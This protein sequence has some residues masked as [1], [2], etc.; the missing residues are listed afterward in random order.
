MAHRFY[1]PPEQCRGDL[2]SLAG[3]EAHHALHVLR[4]GRGDQLSVMNG[5]GEE[6]QCE[7]ADASRDHL[8]LKVLERKQ[9]PVPPSQITL[10]QAVPK[11]KLLES[12]IQ[13]A[14]ELGAARVV[15]L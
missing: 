4:L 12:I 9:F 13:K 6:L 5:A 2:L 1:L 3:R 8:D 14:T 15:P 7:I 11:G 10:L